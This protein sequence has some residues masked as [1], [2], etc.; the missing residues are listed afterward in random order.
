[1]P[2]PTSPPIPIPWRER[3]RNARLRYVPPLIAIAVVFLLALLWKDYASVPMLVGQAESIEANVSCYKSGML[4]ELSVNR[5][6]K[7][8]AG[9]PIGLVLLTDPK[10]LASSLA[11]VQSEIDMIRALRSPNA[12]ACRSTMRCTP[13]F[14]SE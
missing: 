14:D 13:R 5:F 4:A 12:I 10:I 9:D 1:M 2:T 7:V 6:Q 3:W 8:K 11:V